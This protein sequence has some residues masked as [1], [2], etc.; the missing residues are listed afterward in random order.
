MIDDEKTQQ[1]AHTVGT[2]FIEELAKLQ[3][4]FDVIGDVRGKGLMIGVEMV[5]DQ[6][7][8]LYFIGLVFCIFNCC[9][10]FNLIV[11]M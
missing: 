4:Q 2:Y 7:G 10:F 11:Y 9:C 3:K 6:V 8:F 5:T 1:N